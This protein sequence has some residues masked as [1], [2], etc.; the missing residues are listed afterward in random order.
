MKKG[1]NSCLFEGGLANINVSW[2]L[3]PHLWPRRLLH[4]AEMFC[5]K[6]QKG[7]N[8]C[9]CKQKTVKGKEEKENWSEAWTSGPF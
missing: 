9:V 5:S 4:P 8:V 3:S 1:G 2:S 6:T 7:E